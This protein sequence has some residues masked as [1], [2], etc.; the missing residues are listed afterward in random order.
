[1]NW[2]N[3]INY[4]QVH[5]AFERPAFG[6]DHAGIIA[7]NEYRERKSSA[8][9]LFCTCTM[10]SLLVSRSRNSSGGVLIRAKAPLL[11]VQ[12]V[13]DFF[14][15]WCG[16]CK[17]LAPKLDEL[18]KKTPGVVFLK[19]DVDHQEVSASPP[20]LLMSPLALEGGSQSTGL[21]CWQHPVL[22]KFSVAIAFHVCVCF[23]WLAQSVLRSHFKS[24]NC[25]EMRDLLLRAMILGTLHS[26]SMMPST[27]VPEFLCS[28]L[29]AGLLFS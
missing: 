4:Q 14:A 23:L 15:E 13:V 3:T 29:T 22:R 8:E 2:H 24:C 19:V 7:R 21:L 20:S 16:P 18:S 17:V 27:Q 9:Q 25:K 10:K 12:V 5:V 26:L 11:A 6:R 28:E 1:M